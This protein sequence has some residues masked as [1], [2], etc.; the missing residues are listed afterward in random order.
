M[1]NQSQ[2]IKLEIEGKNVTQNMVTIKD[3]RRRKNLHNSSNAYL[4]KWKFTK[5]V[6]KIFNKLSLLASVQFVIAVLPDWMAG[7]EPSV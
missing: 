4:P 1:Q 5:N 6:D 7:I 3:D 2:E